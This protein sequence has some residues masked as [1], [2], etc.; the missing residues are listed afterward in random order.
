MVGKGTDTRLVG[1]VVA[2][3]GAAGGLGAEIAVQCAQAGARV[4]VCD[5]A[6]ANGERIAADIAGFGGDAHYFEFD[7]CDEGAWQRVLAELKTVYGALHALVNN[8]G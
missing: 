3:T 5:V 6:R 4:A 8:A 1:K 2:V 7:V